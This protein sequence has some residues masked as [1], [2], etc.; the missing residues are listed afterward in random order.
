MS[1]VIVLTGATCVSLIRFD[2]VSIAKVTSNDYLK[3][4]KT[5]VNLSSIGLPSSVISYHAKTRLWR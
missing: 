4:Q 1:L 3:A 2:L 5:I